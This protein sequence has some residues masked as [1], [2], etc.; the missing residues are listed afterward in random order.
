MSTLVNKFKDK[1]KDLTYTEKQI[2]YYLNNNLEHAKD[3]TLTEIAEINNVS[4]TTV[5]RMCNKLGL[6]AFSEFKFEMKN[7]KE[8]NNDDLKEQSTYSNIEYTL[9]SM[10]NNKLIEIAEMIKKA[11]K[12]IVVSV[13]LTKPLGEY[14]SKMLM[15]SGKNSNYIYE[16]HMIDLLDKNCDANDLII[17]MSNSGYTKTLC[18]VADKLTCLGLQTV[19]IINSADT[20]LENVVNHTI[21]SNCEKILL[22]GYDLTPRSSLVIVADMLFSIYST[23]K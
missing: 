15:Q 14:F 19:A 18:D 23:I 7:L 3:L 5:I 4:N 10:D 9:K 12:V 20:K 11:N 17:F 16:S 6:S 22:N 21:S 2:F 1:L 8:H 13:G